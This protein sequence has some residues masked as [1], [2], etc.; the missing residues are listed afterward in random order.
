MAPKIRFEAAPEEGQ[1]FVPRCVVEEK[2]A[3]QP[4]E[5]LG[6][7]GGIADHIRPV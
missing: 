4:D 6:Q 3:Q 1:C 7:L 2:M 5:L